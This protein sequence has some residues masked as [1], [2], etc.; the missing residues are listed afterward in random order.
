ML[1]LE[2][3]EKHKQLFSVALMPFCVL[4]IKICSFIKK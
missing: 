1:A 4:Q 2:F 3:K